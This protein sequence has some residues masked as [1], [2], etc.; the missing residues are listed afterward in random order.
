MATIVRSGENRILNLLTDDFQGGTGNGTLLVDG[1]PDLID[2][3]NSIGSANYVNLRIEVSGL[4][5]VELALNPIKTITKNDIREFGSTGKAAPLLE[6]SVFQH[7][8]GMTKDVLRL[9]IN[10]FLNL[11]L[12]GPFTSLRITSADYANIDL[13]NFIIK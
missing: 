2:I 11:E 4:V 3:R 8:Y 9:E 1:G 5:L 6:E 13:I 7:D 10:D 12:P